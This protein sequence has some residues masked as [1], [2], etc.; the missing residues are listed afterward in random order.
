MIRHNAGWISNPNP[1]EP[2]RERI[3]QMREGAGQDVRLAT[4][5]TATETRLLAR[6]SINLGL[7]RVA[8]LL[9]TLPK[10]ESLRLLDDNAAMVDRYRGLES[11]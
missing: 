10:D 8:L 9:P 2:M 3:N 7:G 4:F 11:V 1:V 5:G 6:A